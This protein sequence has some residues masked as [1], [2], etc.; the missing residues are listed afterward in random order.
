MV[1]EKG[2]THGIGKFDGTNYAFQRMQIKYY[3]YCKKL[4]LPLSGMKPKR[5]LDNDWS[6]F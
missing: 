5:M 4:H 2:S 1:S 3:L 6:P